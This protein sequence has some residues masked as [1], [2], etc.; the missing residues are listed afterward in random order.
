MDGAWK[1]DDL[2]VENVVRHEREK[3]Q[4]NL[5]SSLF[6]STELLP[7]FVQMLDTPSKAMREH[8]FSVLKAT[9]D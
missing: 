8:N 9:L 7:I 1:D 5:S 6:R 2:S 3:L 4:L